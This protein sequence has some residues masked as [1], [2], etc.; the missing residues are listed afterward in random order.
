MKCSWK[1]VTL[2]QTVSESGNMCV[3]GNLDS[4][5]GRRGDSPPVINDM[6]K[7]VFTSDLMNRQRGL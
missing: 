6:T 5:M 2:L 4:W 1:P 3:K 7:D